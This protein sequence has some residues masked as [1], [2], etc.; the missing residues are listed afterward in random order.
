M[1]RT[2]ST[3]WARRCTFSTPIRRQDFLENYI[4][5]FTRNLLSYLVTTIRIFVLKR[6]LV[7]ESSNIPFIVPV[8]ERL[9]FQRRPWHIWAAPLHLPHYHP[10]RKILPVTHPTPRMIFPTNIAIYLNIFRTPKHSKKS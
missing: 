2:P 6:P 10:S 5:S 7:A 4:I 3:R 8:F 9:K 1:P